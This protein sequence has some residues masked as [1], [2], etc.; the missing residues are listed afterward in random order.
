MVSGG[1]WLFLVVLGLGGSL[2]LLVV[3]HGFFL[4]FLGVLGDSWS[5]SVFFL[6]LDRK[7]KKNRTTINH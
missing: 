5:F 2:W 4:C 3:L 6:V 7:K 1:S